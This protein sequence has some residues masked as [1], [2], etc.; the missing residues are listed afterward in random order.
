MDARIVRPDPSGP[1]QQL[2]R[3]CVLAPRKMTIREELERLQIVRLH[4]EQA[5]EKRLRQDRLAT[6][7]MFMRQGAASGGVVVERLVHRCGFILTQG[8]RA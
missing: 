8:H 6:A 3:T 7:Q 5:C 4:A 1:L 2:D